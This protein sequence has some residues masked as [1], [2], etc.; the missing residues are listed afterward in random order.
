MVAAKNIR[1]SNF[2]LLRIVLMLLV[3]LI[4]YT[5]VRIVDMTGGISLTDSIWQ[6]LANLELKSLSIVCVNCFVLIS[7]YFGIKLKLRSFLNLIFQMVYWSA[8]CVAFVAVASH[9]FGH[10]SIHH[11]YQLLSLISFQVGSLRLT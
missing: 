6:D 1:E 3:L 7:G 5:P 4:H 10:P 2:E 8:I 11:T 9:I